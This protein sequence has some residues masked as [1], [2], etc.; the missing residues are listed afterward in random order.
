MI[1]LA[2]LQYIINSIWQVPLLALVTWLLIRLGRPEARTQSRLWMATLALAIVLPLRGAGALQAHPAAAGLPAQPH[3]GLAVPMAQPAS[4]AID[5]ASVEARFQRHPGKHQAPGWLAVQPRMRTL[6]VPVGPRMA[7]WM[8]AI[9]LCL[10]A[11]RGVQLAF[12]WSA[13]RGLLRSAR[14][15][16][17]TQR[18]LAILQCLCRKFSVSEPLVLCSAQLVSPLTVGG[19]RPVLLLPETFAAN[20]ENEVAAMLGHELAHIRRRDYLCNLAGHVAALPIAFHPATRA[21][22]RRLRQSREM[23]CDA[24]AAEAMHS[25]SSYASCLIGLAQRMLD[26]RREVE[27]ALAV[28]LFD[29]GSLEE[30]IMRLLETKTRMSPRMKLVRGT[31]GILLLASAAMTATLLHLTP[32]VAEAATQTPASAA[33]QATGQAA[34]SAQPAAT[35]TPVAPGKTRRLAAKTPKLATANATAEEE[36]LQM[37]SREFKKQMDDA[38]QQMAEAAKQL[39]SDAVQRQMKILQ[40]PEFKKQMEDARQQ[41]AE[42]DKQLQ[43]DA[44]QRQMKILQSPEFKKQMDDARQQ[45]AEA[46]KQ[47]QSDAV[48]RQMKILQSPEFKKQMEDARQQI[49]E[50]AK[51]CRPAADEDIAE[52]RIQKTDG[53]CPPAD[54]RSRQTVAKRCRPARDEDAVESRI[55]KADGGHAASAGRCGP[56]DPEKRSHEAVDGI[57]GKGRQE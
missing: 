25:S 46:A 4:A 9:Y 39:Q 38:R 31:A 50:A 28:G 29:N 49:A 18:E 2:L 26:G 5:G 48:Q 47:L 6:S 23:V 17:L 14:A 16:V 55:Q 22:Q 13:A 40:S 12:A 35:T 36:T 32:T 53:R 11:F 52:S 8:L 42:A 10:L 57:D 7:A 44:V 37:Q 19:I 51:R 24:M 34:P 27:R 20:T 56:A 43:S 21:I 54:G 41:I 15:A 30:R 1:R 3:A 33:G 45:M